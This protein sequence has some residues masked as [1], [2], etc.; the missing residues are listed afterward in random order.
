MTMLIFCVFQVKYQRG[1]KEMKGRSC[2]ELD[3]PEL[4][5][6][7]KS[8]NDISMV[9]LRLPWRL[10]RPWSELTRVKHTAGGTAALLTHRA[11]ELTAWLLP[12]M[13]EP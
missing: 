12:F 2:N 11:K 5:R 3:T 4:R 7:R 9:E 10:R 8:Q 1:M 13:M 6:V